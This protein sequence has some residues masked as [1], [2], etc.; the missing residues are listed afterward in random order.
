MVKASQ[1]LALELLRSVVWLFA[2]GFKEVLSVWPCF[3]SVFGMLLVS[4]VFFGHTN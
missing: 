3:F 4:V 2:L 1:W